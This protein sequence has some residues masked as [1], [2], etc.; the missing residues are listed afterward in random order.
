MS[1][2]THFCGKLSQVDEN[3]QVTLAGWVDVRR[4]LG[5]VIFIELRD[6]SGKVQLVADPVINQQV[7]AIFESLKPEF[8]I[9]VTG[10]VKNRPHGTENPDLRTGA[11]EI[12]P[13][14]I[15][16]L[17]KSKALPLPLKDFENADEFFRLKYRYLDLRRPEMQKNIRLRHKITHAVR[18]Y[19]VENDYLEIETPMLTKST[20]EGARDYL[21]PSR[22]QEGKFFALPQS[23]Q[24]FKQ[25]L[26]VSGFE[27]YF[28]IA[29]CFRDEDLR[30]DRQPEFT[31]IDI[32]LSFATVDLII[33]LIE[34]L[35]K[36]IFKSIDLLP[37]GTELEFLRMNY[38]DAMNL[39]GIDKPDLRFD[40]K[41]IDFTNL[42]SKS[43]FQSFSS[44]TQKGGLVKGLCIQTNNWSRK[45]FDDLRNLA[46]TREYGA[47]G[48][49]WI[50]FKPDNTISSPI[51]KFFTEQELEEIKNLANIKN[52][53][54]Q[55][56][57][58]Y[59]VFFV[60]DSEELVHQV[61]GRLRN[62]LGEKLNLIDKKAHK[63]VWILNW[64][65]FEKDSETGKL[66]AMHHP[67]TAVNPED[68]NLLNTSPE[69]AR[70]LAYDIVYNGFELGGGSI[71]NCHEED[72]KKVFDILGISEE[73]AEEKFGFLLQALSMGAPPHG[74]IALGLDRIVMLLSGESSLRQVIAFPKVQS[75]SCPLTNAPS[76]VKQEQL[77][78]LS[79]KLNLKKK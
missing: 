77:D 31:Q 59:S 73:E 13:D 29:R 51:A 18:E 39:Y 25:L 64:P 71:R 35:L 56:E 8:C 10:K 38:K 69:N 50:T 75:A 63:F 14:K 72:Q 23:P 19:L 32:E 79:L 34:G 43:S 5:G 46:V 74:G 21:V 27:K 12:Y 49:A 54:S 7:Y 61:L 55:E 30:A 41:L 53:N 20:P 33:N 42:M 11:V 4:D 57:K 9:Q 36:K 52:N 76:E 22:V 3:I 70:A 78:E 60:A 67:F 47:K 44:I 1:I 28:Q 45:E 62:Y 17:N 24:L 26:M 66:N 40:M 48:L 68:K 15:N 2:R 37:D 58:E 16:I 65:V 6:H